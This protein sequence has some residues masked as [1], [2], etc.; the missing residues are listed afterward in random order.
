MSEELL[1]A[2]ALKSSK[3]FNLIKNDFSLGLG[4]AYLIISQDDEAVQ[5]FFR[6][7]AC[8][9]E[10]DQHNSACLE[11]DSCLQVLHYNYPDVKFF[12]QEKTPIK[13]EVM[14]AYLEESRKAPVIIKENR[15]LLYKIKEFKF[16]EKFVN[17][18]LRTEKDLE[19]NIIDLS[20]SEGEKQIICLCRIM[21]KNNKIIIM[22]EAT[23]NIDL[24]TEK[25]IYNDFINKI[26]KETTIISILHKLDYINYYDKVVELSDDGRIKN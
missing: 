21:I 26:S 6:L 9:V 24:E 10:C 3:A 16:M 12:N 18:Y 11:C 13:A 22:D 17:K 4:N 2:N 7:I 5:S 14:R 15:T 19:K 23:S 25:L 20:L 8:A 1:F